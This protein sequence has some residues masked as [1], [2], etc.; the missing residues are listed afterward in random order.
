[1]NLHLRTF[2]YCLKNLKII[3]YIPPKTSKPLSVATETTVNKKTRKKQQ[4]KKTH[5]LKCHCYEAHSGA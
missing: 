3:C 2:K 4:N 5:Q 1:M